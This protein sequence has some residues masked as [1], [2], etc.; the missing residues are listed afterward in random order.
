MDAVYWGK[1]GTRLKLWS[2]V[3]G[4]LIGRVGGTFLYQLKNVGEV[5]TCWGQYL[6]VWK[7][8]YREQAAL[9]FQRP[10]DMIWGRVWLA[11]AASVAWPCLR[12]CQE[13]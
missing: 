2:V 9:D 11:M 10:W 4:R 8:R 6:G 7:N 1:F 12:L 5:E 3:L 13:M